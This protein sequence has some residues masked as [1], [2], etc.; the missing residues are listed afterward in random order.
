MGEVSFKQFPFRS[1]AVNVEP[2]DEPPP[3]GDHCHARMVAHFRVSKDHFSQ[4]PPLGHVGALVTKESN[5][6]YYSRKAPFTCFLLVL[7]L[8]VTKLSASPLHFDSIYWLALDSMCYECGYLC[9]VHYYSVAHHVDEDVFRLV[10]SQLE[11]VLA[12][13]DGPRQGPE[14]EGGVGRGEAVHQVEGGAA[15]AEQGVLLCSQLYRTVI[16]DP[17]CL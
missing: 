11:L 1:L 3:R 6:F 16:T 9:T 2:L 14:H 5:C 10:V 13:C 4:S 8:F 15:V 7:P 17:Y 12:V